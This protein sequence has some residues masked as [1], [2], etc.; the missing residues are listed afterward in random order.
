MNRTGSRPAGSPLFRRKTDKEI[1]TK[2][3]Q[4]WKPVHIRN[5]ISSIKRQRAEA[6]IGWPLGLLG[7]EGAVH[8]ESRNT[9]VLGTDCMEAGSTGSLICLKN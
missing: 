4:K 1:N 6:M 8:S 7:G 5:G 2:N 9:C 3:K